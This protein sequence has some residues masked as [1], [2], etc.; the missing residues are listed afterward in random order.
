[1][2]TPA[3]AIIARP[4]FSKQHQ[5]LGKYLPRLSMAGTTT[6]N[7]IFM[8]I[9]LTKESTTYWTLGENPSPSFPNSEVEKAKIY[10]KA[11]RDIYC[12]RYLYFVINTKHL[13]PLAQLAESKSTHM[14]VSEKMSNFFDI[15][16]QN[17]KFCPIVLKHVQQSVV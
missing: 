10:I 13:T 2:G 1:M 8:D 12:N 5:I 14:Y 11:Q 7:S 17:S 15:S 4:W 16:L 9:A 6:E 3:L